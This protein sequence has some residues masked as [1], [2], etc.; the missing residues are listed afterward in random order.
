MGPDWRSNKDN[1]SVR[2]W[3]LWKELETKERDGVEGARWA[4]GRRPASTATYLPIPSRQVYIA[5]N[6][7]LSFQH[8]LA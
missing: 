6:A 3:L 8:L 5:G 2:E 7:M 4:T 1:F